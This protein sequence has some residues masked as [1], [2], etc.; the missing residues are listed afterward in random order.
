M[1]AS[2]CF[3]SHRA[4]PADRVEPESARAEDDESG[5]VFGSVSRDR[6][7]RVGSDDGGVAYIDSGP[8]SAGIANL[9]DL[10]LECPNAIGACRH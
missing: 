9:A 8:A 2:D 7:G 3:P 4:H 5:V 6:R 10:L 1:H